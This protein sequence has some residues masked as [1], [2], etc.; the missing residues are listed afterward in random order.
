MT[1]NT[2]LVLGI[3]LGTTYSVVAIHQQ[4]D[5]LVVPDPITGSFRVPSVIQFSGDTVIVGQM[6][7]D[8]LITHPDSVVELVKR[9]MG[10]DRVF[11]FAGRT[12]GPELISSL[13]LSSLVNN[14]RTCA[15]VGP[16]VPVKAVIT[17]PAYFGTAE[18]EATHIAGELA[19][20]DVLDLVAEPV[21][22]AAAFGDTG[23]VRRIL[24]YDLG[25]GTFDVTVLKS[26]RSG[27]T[28]MST[29]GDS[30]LGGADWDSR[31]IDMVG[32]RFLTTIGAD[33]E[34]REDFWDDQEAMARLALAATSLKENLTARVTAH[35]TVSWRGHTETIVVERGEF[36]AATSD[37][38]AR[39]LDTTRQAL[40]DSGLGEGPLI[41]EVIL[42]GGSSRMPMIPAALGQKL[43][44]SPRLVDPDLVVAKGA[45]II[46]G[47]LTAKS[48]TRADYRSVVPRSLGVL[49]H[50]SYDPQARR[51]IVQHIIDRNTALPAHATARFATIVRGQ[52][53][54]HLQVMEQAGQMPSPEPQH[55]RRVIDAQLTVTAE[56]PAGSPIDV[57]LDVAVDGRITV[58][59]T[60]PTSG[61]RVELEYYLDQVTEGRSLTAQRE[62]LSGITVAQ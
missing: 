39:T 57:A 55:N 11:G 17:V 62:S 18:R 54:V 44:V 31:L 19:G 26:R 34:T 50:D 40:T 16:G 53:T 27:V 23:A 30:A 61:S 38:V 59:G 7:K 32:T 12:L 22:A 42:V 15:G 48:P 24:V 13:I 56:L 25:G 28:V 37:L 10:T 14:A 33:E 47:T 21:A 43:G 3:D 4:G 9:S 52:P 41:D 8:A 51:Q 1:K 35:V 29:G 45:A 6:A 60:E 49:L 46:A 58:S 2:D 5:P 36:E 20:L